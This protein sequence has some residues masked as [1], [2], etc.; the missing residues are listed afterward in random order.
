MLY[1]NLEPWDFT[2]KRI[3][4]VAGMIA[5]ASVHEVHKDHKELQEMLQDM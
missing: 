3:E 4:L 2:G 5:M 1:P